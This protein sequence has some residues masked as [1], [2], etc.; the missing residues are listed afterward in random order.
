M[1]PVTGG[2]GTGTS[3]GTGAGT[4]TK[5]NLN[6]ATKTELMTLPGI[7]DAKATSIIS[8]RPYTDLD[9]AKARIKGV[10]WGTLEALVKVE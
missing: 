7:A 1:P 10:V 3:P 2:G 9:D 6:K 4:V 5:L 8:D